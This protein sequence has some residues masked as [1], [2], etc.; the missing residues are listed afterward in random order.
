[1]RNR[2]DQKLQTDRRTDGPTDRLTDRQANSYIPPQ[3]EFW[4]V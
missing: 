2:A 4:G 3:T 1:M